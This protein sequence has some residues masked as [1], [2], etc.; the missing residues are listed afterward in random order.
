MH[1]NLHFTQT[2]RVISDHRAFALACGDI[3][4]CGPDDIYL[5]LYPPQWDGGMAPVLVRFTRPEDMRTLGQALLDA[6]CSLEARDA[7]TRSDALAFPPGD[8]YVGDLC[9]VLAQESPV[10]AKLDEAYWRNAEHGTYAAAIQHEGASAWQARTAYGDGTYSD[11]QGRF[12][13][14]DSGTIGI[15]SLAACDGTKLAEMLG[16]HTLGHVIT[17]AEGCTPTCDSGV[18]H[19]GPVTIDTRGRSDEEGD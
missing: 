6:V 10:G 16:Q 9:Y 11:E 3:L 7:A 17:L 15:L 14:V 13:G 19:I 18:F 5:S 4:V 12:Y 8:Y 1:I 2:A